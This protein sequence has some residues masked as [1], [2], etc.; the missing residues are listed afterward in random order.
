MSN[1]AKKG[2]NARRAQQIA[3]EY[4]AEYGT[5]DAALDAV[6][7]GSGLDWEGVERVC[8]ELELLGEGT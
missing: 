2:F 7:H 6:V 3:Q 8:V 4:L 1:L 5:V